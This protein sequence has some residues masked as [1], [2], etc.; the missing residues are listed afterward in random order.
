[1]S[2]SARFDAQTTAALKKVTTRLIPFLFVL[3]V[4]NYLDRINIGFAALQMN[5][6]LGL[7][8]TVFGLSST[9]FYLGY[10]ACEVPSNLLLAR[11]GARKWIA[12]ILVS[13]GLASAV[14]MFVNSATTLHLARFLLG[15]LEAGFVPGV[16]LYLTYWFPTAVRARANS[17]MIMGQPLAM[18]IGAAMSGAIIQH[19]DGLAGFSGWRWMFLIEGLPATILGIIAFFYLADRP[20]FATWLKPE[21]ALALEREIAT[22]EGS[23]AKLR[24][25]DV[26]MDGRLLLLG[27]AYFGL[28][29]TLNANATWTPTILRDVMAA[30]SLTSVGLY[31]AIPP[32]FAL[33]AMPL[34]AQ[35]SDLR[36]DRY[37]HVAIALLV[38]AIGWMSVMVSS[39]PMLRL[40]GLTLT[41]AGSLSAMV[42]FWAI[43][44]TI[45]SPQARPAGIGI[46]SSIGLLGSA[47]SPTVFGYLKDLTHSFTAG[48]IYV[49]VLLLISIAI[50]LSLRPRSRKQNARVL[51]QSTK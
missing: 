21:E 12:R 40:A 5:K 28:C 2:E 31:A 9:I 30:Y 39:D 4:F 35:S 51:L 47:L 23:S 43:P 7:T 36:N 34:W 38:T 8:A 37:W 17:L 14:T 26:L 11:F 46:I 45:L 1:M 41:T 49:A 3:Y 16:I 48:L 15:V 20:R 50:I 19:L 44:Q 13:W 22:E 6:E 27:A 29:N 25:V 24:F 33:I 18:L 10:V 42:V 32:L